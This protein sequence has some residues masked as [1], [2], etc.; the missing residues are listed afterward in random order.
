MKHFPQSLLAKFVGPG[1]QAAVLLTHICHLYGG[2]AMKVTQVDQTL[3]I[4]IGGRV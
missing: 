3:S 2:L 1:P 4:Y